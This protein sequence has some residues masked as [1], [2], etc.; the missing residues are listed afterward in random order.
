MNKEAIHN[1]TARIAQ[2]SRS[3]LIVILYEMALTEIGEAR[4]AHADGNLTD[5][6]KGLKRA[7]R[8]VSELM[9]TL[10][11]RYPIAYDLLSLYIYTNRELIRALY[12]GDAQLLDDPEQVLRKLLIGFEGVSKQDTSGPV[13]RNSQ[14]LYAGLTYGKGKLNETYLNPGNGN[15]GFIA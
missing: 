12:K 1:F 10:D 6:E 11:Y 4:Q 9:A 3:E 5:Y 7:Q 15:R 13:M 14:Q 2:A 8:C